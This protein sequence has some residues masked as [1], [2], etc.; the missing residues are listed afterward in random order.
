MRPIDGQTVLVTGTTSGLG[1]RLV[2]RLA[3]SGVTVIAH[4][5]DSARLRRI[6]EEIREATG[7]EV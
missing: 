6:R 7:Q 1:R 4:G 2:A 3:A 5:R